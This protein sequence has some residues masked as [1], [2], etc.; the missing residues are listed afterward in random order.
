MQSLQ[1]QVAAEQVQYCT[2]ATCVIFTKLHCTSMHDMH[3]TTRKASLR[4]SVTKRIHLRHLCH[5]IKSSIAAAPLG[6]CHHCTTIAI[7]Q[8]A[9]LLM[10]PLSLMPSRC[11]AVCRYFMPVPLLG[12][13]TLP[14]SLIS[15]HIGQAMI[16]AIA[17]ATTSRPRLKP[18]GRAICC[19]LC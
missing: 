17:W 9:L 3:K 12:H 1:Q 13:A 14:H 11:K 7:W 8:T 2:A 18:C 16:N 15:F 10:I 5:E 19:V 6:T 4:Q